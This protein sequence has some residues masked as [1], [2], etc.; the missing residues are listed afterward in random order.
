MSVLNITPRERMTDAQGRPYF[1][2]DCDLT[3]DGFEALLRD[4][5]PEVRAYNLG[6]LM[7]QARPDDVFAFVTLRE[8]RAAWP[9]A[10]RYLG[11]TRAFWSWILDRWENGD[12]VDR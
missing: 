12:G 7:R 2:W 8:I 4:A 3:L 10:Q 1:L 9:L 11:R 5:D 6:R